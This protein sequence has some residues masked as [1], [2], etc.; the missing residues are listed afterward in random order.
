M[1]GKTIGNYRIVEKLGKG[2][3]GT[4]FK[5]VDDTLGREVAVKLLHADVAQTDVMKRFQMEVKALAKLNHP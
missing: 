3:T 5:A 2:A 4:V 1:I